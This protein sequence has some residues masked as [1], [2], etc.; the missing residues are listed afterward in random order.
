MNFSFRELK[1]SIMKLLQIDS[2]LPVASGLLDQGS[3]WM[4]KIKDMALAYAPKVLG[5]ILVYLIGQWLIGRIGAIIKKMLSNKN[6]DVSLQKFLVSIVKVTL[7]ILM[8]LAI[9]GMLGVNITSFAALLAGA[10]LAIGAALNGSLGN[11]AG[12]VMLMVFKPF[13]VGDLIEA[14]DSLGLV[15]EIGIFNTTILSPE[16]KTVIL[17][18]GALSTGVIT[19]Y[20]THG[21][22]RVDLKMAISVNQNI[23]QARE[24]AIGA[25]KQHAMV[26]AEPTPEVSVLEVADGMT[27]L[28]IRPYTTQDNY[29]TVYFEVQELVKKAFDSNN[30][31]GPIPHNVIVNRSNN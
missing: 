31:E 18:N 27:T 6:F 24:V 8:F 17:P 30:I 28:A 1:S 15:T 23:D 3:I 13:K 11:L 16:N 9:I 20:N 7:T 25:M 21:N 2:T 4:E 19:N 29:W 22:L 26:L 5:A 10:G 14:Q 12:G